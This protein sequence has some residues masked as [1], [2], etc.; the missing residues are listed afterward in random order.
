MGSSHTSISRQTTATSHVGLV[1][2][3]LWLCVVPATTSHAAGGVLGVGGGYHLP[4]EQLDVLGSE[5]APSPLHGG[6]F[7]GLHGGYHLIDRF[8][9]ATAQREC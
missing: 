5:L 4:S 7:I 2:F 1:F 6:P 3:I 8:A 9:L